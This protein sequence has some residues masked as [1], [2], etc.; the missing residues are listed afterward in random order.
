VRSPEAILD[1][2]R[3]AM[4]AFGRHGELAF[5]AQ[6]LIEIEDK[7]SLAKA[8]YD[9]TQA[10]RVALQMKQRELRAIAAD[11]QKELVRL[12]TAVRIALGTSHIDYQRLRVRTARPDAELPDDSTSETTE[13][14]PESGPSQ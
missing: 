14:S 4:Q 7:H 12:R 6:A 10:G 9:G 11:V 2:A 5:A 3:Q 1:N 13:S 8:A